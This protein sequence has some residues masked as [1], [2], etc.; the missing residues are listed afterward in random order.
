MRK[1]IYH[2]LLLDPAEALKSWFKFKVVVGCRLGN[3]GDD[4]DVVAFGTYVMST[5]NDGNVDIYYCKH[6]VLAFMKDTYHS[7]VQLGI[8]E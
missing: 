2:E 8:G 6:P 5:G 7:C 4:G 1:G 3:G